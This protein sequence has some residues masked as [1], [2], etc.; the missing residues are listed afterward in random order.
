MGSNDVL[1]NGRPA[2]RVGD[3]GIHAV[4]CGPNMWDAV[5]GSPNVMINGK[6]AHRVNDT[7]MH[8]GG[9]GKMIEGSTDVLI[10]G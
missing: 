8:C 7:D 2:V 5:Q 4:C 6:P 10:N 9:V 3:K 1:I